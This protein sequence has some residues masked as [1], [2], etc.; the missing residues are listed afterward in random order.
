MFLAFYRKFAAPSKLLH[1]LIAKYEEGSRSA[2]DYMLKMIVQTRYNP[3]SDTQT[4]PH[5]FIPAHADFIQMLRH[6][7]EM[8]PNLPPRFQLPNNPHRS[9][10]LHR[11]TRLN[12][13][14]RPLRK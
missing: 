4:L 2:I 12:L 3:L 8:A 13:P 6:P 9:P 14:P 5:P 11:P 1:S 7:N 10:H